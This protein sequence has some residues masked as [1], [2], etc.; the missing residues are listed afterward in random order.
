[1]SNE[2]S[3]MNSTNGSSPVRE[4][5]TSDEKLQLL[6][7]ELGADSLEEALISVRALK[8]RAFGASSE[9]NTASPLTSEGD[10]PETLNDPRRLLGKLRAFTSK[11][12]SLNGTIVSMENQLKSLYADRERLEREIGASE[13]DDVVAAFGFLQTTIRSMENQLM[14]LYA[15][16]ETLEVELGKSDP[17]EIV[18]MFRNIA[19][20]VRG[21]H[22]ELDYSNLKN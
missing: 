13:V 14:T 17:T 7:T 18:A 11:I 9:S 6:L 12:D 8:N 19:Q 4:T 20:L 2:T 10:T 1:M 21:V 3:N 15:G 16:R 5:T 22:Q